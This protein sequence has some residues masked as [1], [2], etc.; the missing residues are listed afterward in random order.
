MLVCIEFKGRQDPGAREETQVNDMFSAP[1]LARF[2]EMWNAEPELSGALGR[3]GFDA[4]IGYGFKGDN[5]PRGVLI[6]KD[7]MVVAARLYSGELLDWDLRAD[8]DTWQSWLTQPPGM[9]SL[10]MAYTTSRL[11]FVVGDYAAII[12]DPRMAVPFMK[13]FSVMARA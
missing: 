3:I 12:K 11:Q 7:G 8:A 1:W 9:V 5:D 2:G 4:T 6:V 10:G 13:S